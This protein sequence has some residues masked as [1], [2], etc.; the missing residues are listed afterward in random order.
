M[1]SNNAPPKFNIAFASGAGSSFTRQIPQASQIGVTNGAASLADGFPPSTFSPI[2]AGGSWP[3]G[4]DF[5][6]LLNQVTSWD[7]WFQAG[8]PVFFDAAFSTAI[9]GYPKGAE[10]SSSATNGLVWINQIDNNTTNPDSGGTNWTPSQQWRAGTVTSVSGATV[11]GGTLIIPAQ[12][13]TAGNVSS[14]SGGTVAGGVLTIPAGQWNAGAVTNV[15]G[16]TISGGIMTIP[17][18]PSQQWTAGGVSSVSGGTVSGGVLSIPAPPAQQW[19]AGSVSRVSGGTISGGTLTIAAAAQEWTAGNVSGVSG[20][21]VSGGILTVPT[22][23]FTASAAQNGYQK[24]PSGVV[25]QWGVGITSSGQGDPVSFP[26]TFPNACF[27][28]IANE[29]NAVGWTAPAISATVHGVQSPTVNGFSIY[30]VRLSPTGTGA[31]APSDA[32]SWIA[33]G[34]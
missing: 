32:Y 33:V 29:R 6:G 9:G 1:Q 27:T 21:T 13:W 11:S 25:I 24:L 18:A 4:Q 16:A 26:L 17:S 34:H 14:V 7:R 2:S 19:T 12:E 15:V 10:L 3:F 30:V 20:A 5:N 22:Y 8:G 28:V 31:Y 23:V